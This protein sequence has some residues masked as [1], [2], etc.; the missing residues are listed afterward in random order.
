VGPP[1]RGTARQ[2]HST[3]IVA[4]NARTP[5]PAPW[6]LA[7]GLELVQR[8]RNLRL[9][10]RNRF[11]PRFV[12][13][14]LLRGQSVQGALMLGLRL[15]KQAARRV[16]RVD[17]RQRLSGFI[18]KLLERRPQS[19]RIVDEFQKFE[20]RRNGCSANRDRQRQRVSKSAF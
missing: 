14:D 1:A 18:R 4:E 6:S 15:S 2:A 10:G 17:H 19:F 7:I 8:V 20:S 5:L 13:A 16:G 11:Q 9:A 3:K 12:L